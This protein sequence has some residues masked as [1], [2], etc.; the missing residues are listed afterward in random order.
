MT[1]A[2]IV[3]NLPCILPNLQIRKKSSDGV[4]QT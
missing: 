3:Q 1:Y 4:L 2:A